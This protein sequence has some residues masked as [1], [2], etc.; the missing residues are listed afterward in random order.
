MTAL[1]DPW[2]VTVAPGWGSVFM[3]MIDSVNIA[4]ILMDG[5]AEISRPIM[6]ALW[7]AARA[8]ARSTPAEFTSSTWRGVL[9]DMSTNLCATTAQWASTFETMTPPSPN[10]PEGLFAKY[11][12]GRNLVPA[13]QLPLRRMVFTEELN[14]FSFDYG[15]ENRY[16]KVAHGVRTLTQEGSTS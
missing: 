6:D 8:D 2:T 5:E 4:T 1:D 14:A 3:S 10:S 12:R 16:L 9:L 11:H 15:Y 13:S 7:V